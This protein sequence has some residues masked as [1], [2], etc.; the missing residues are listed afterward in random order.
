[1]LPVDGVFDRAS[2]RAMMLMPDPAVK[3]RAANAQRVRAPGEHRA[4]PLQVRS[5]RDREH[6]RLV[7]RLVVEDNE[8]IGRTAAAHPEMTARGNRRHA[9][10]RDATRRPMPTKLRNMRAPF[11]FEWPQANARAVPQ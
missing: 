9:R 8:C 3:H 5:R 6:V 11:E 10:C 7:E 4:D 2:S 1:M